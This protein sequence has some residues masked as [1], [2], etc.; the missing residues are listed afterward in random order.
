MSARDNEALVREGHAAYSDH[1]LD[2]AVANYA[3]DAERLNVATG[4]TFRGPEGHKDYLRG[5]IDAFPDSK[6]EITEV[7]AGDD[8]AVVEFVGRGTHEGTL[9]S[10]DG[11]VP[12]TGRPVEIRFCEVHRISDGKIFI[13]RSYFDLAGMLAQLGLVPE[14]EE[15]GA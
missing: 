4:E 7:L 12:P 1:D 6:T 14:P 10:F 8:F 9:R 5:W 11:E 3:E 13:T 15:A 2:R